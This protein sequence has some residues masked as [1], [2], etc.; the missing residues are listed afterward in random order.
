MQLAF[1]APLKPPTHD[2][3]SGDR[4]M[5]RALMNA[6]RYIGADVTL[7]STLRTRDGVGDA[8]VQRKLIQDAAQEATRLVAVGRTA[9]WDAW[10]TYH[11]YYKAPDLIGPHVAQALNIPY[12]QIETSRSRKR[13]TGPWAQFA[14]ASEDAADAADVIFYLT[15]RDAE[16][17]RR[18]ASSGQHLIHL[19]PFLDCEAL[20]ETSTLAGPVL[21]VGMMRQGDKL[22]SYQI[23]AET[24]ALLPNGNWQLHIAGDGPARAAVEALM[25]P[26]GDAVTFLG[27]LDK[28]SMVHAYHDAS[29]LFWPGVNEAFGLTY[30]EAQAAGVPI[31]AQDRPGVREVLA[32]GDYPMPDAGAAALAQRLLSLTTSHQRRIEAGILIRAHVKAHHLLPAAAD[33]LRQGLTAV[34]IST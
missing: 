27:K 14:Q 5:G 12:L 16:T 11:N 4:A 8:Q 33:T 1:Y 23:I 22:A 32:P 26:Y 31:V 15:E 3:P 20:P 6:L 18:D 7:A 34:G 28:Q 29:A 2:V 13:L 17:L 10:V 9:G 30:L 25:A 24:L 21:A 19:R